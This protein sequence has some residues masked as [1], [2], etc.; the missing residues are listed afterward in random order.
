LISGEDRLLGFA[1]LPLQDPEEAVAELERSVERLGF[2]GAHIG[3]SAG[4]RGLDSPE[5]EPLFAAAER[6]GVPLMLHPY[7]VGPKPGLEDY[8]FTNSIGNPLDTCVAAARLIHAGVLDR[9][10]KLQ[11][12][13]VHGGGFLP[14]QLG[15]LDHAHA[16]RTEPGQRMERAPSEYFE[17]LWLD[18]ITHGDASLSFLRS[19][20]PDRLILG[21]DLP[22]DMGDP[23]PLDRLTRAGVDAHALGASA[24]RLLRL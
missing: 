17:R 4:A 18:T 21:T 3:T 16:V 11:L 1:T 12:V 13:L 2:R 24:A 7:Y 23:Q 20:V 6:L 19:L 14:Y 5:L 22:F 9:F 15:R 10:A 8:Y